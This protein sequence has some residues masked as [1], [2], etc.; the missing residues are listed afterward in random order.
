MMEVIS[1]SF[2]LEKLVNA[3]SRQFR[4]EYPAWG[5]RG[6]FASKNQK[7]TRLWESYPQPDVFL[8]LL[9]MQLASHVGK[10]KAQN[11]RIAKYRLH[12]LLQM[13]CKRLQSLRFSRLLRHIWLFRVK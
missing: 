8:D 5:G 9:K 12:L 2:I 7:L 11:I 1:I 13:E 3:L 4:L 6:I 10:F